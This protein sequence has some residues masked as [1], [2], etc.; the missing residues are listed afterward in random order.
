MS[1]AIKDCAWAAGGTILQTCVEP[2]RY[3][4]RRIAGGLQTKGKNRNYSNICVYQ[5]LALNPF[6]STKILGSHPLRVKIHQIAPIFSWPKP[7]P[8]LAAN[9]WVSI[10]LVVALL[11]RILGLAG[12]PSRLCCCGTLQVQGAGFPDL[13]AARLPPG[14]HIYLG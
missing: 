3:L 13:Y 1:G 14:Q 6:I 10:H 11:G 12:F 4:R 5:I 7:G 9:P 2:K 8:V